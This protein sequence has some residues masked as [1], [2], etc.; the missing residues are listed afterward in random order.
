MHATAAEI[1]NDFDLLIR[2]GA[3][4]GGVLFGMQEEISQLVADSK[5]FGTAIPENMKPWIEE[6]LRAGLLTDE[7]GVKLTSLEGIKFGEPVKTE[8]EKITDALGDL[9]AKMDAFVNAIADATADRTQHIT[10]QYHDPG[11]PPG[12]FDDPFAMPGHAAGGV[13]SREHVARIA[14]GGRAEIV[15]DVPFMTRALTGALQ[16]V[17]SIEASV[18]GSHRLPVSAFGG[19]TSIVVGDIH[20]GITAESVDR[21]SVRELAYEFK[22]AMEDDIGLKILVGVPT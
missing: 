10:R 7:N 2:G 21:S 18:G 6:L 14:E 8:F 3:D 1:I 16:R 9:I 11:P 4:V 22:R 20:I 5:R 17:A 15:G 13:F 19:G 12:W